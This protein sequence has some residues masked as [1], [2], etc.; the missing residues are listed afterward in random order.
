MIRFDPLLSMSV[1]AE[2]ENA[3][4]SIGELKVTSTEGTAVFRG[5]GETGA[6]AVTLSEERICT[7]CWAAVGVGWTLPAL[8]VAML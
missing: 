8:S 6:I 7:V 2:S 1:N 4:R 3:A 5:L